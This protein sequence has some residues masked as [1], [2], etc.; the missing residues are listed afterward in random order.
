[1][2]CGA[3]LE[4]MDKLIFMGSMLINPENPDMSLNCRSMATE[5]YKIDGCVKNQRISPRRNVGVEDIP[6]MDKLDN[7]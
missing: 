7:L 6:K 1:M 3:L 4:A 5:T 2:A